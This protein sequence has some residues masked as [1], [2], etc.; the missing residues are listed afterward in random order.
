MSSSGVRVDVA[1]VRL[2][3]VRVRRTAPARHNQEQV[4][5][6]G[7]TPVVSPD[8]KLREDG[9]LVPAP[10]CKIRSVVLRPA[11]EGPWPGVLL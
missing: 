8:M 3:G 10:D 1:L 9:V 11:G 5:A 4:R 6:G 2:R 7:G